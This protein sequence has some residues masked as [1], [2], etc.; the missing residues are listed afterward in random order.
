MPIHLKTLTGYSISV[1][2]PTTVTLGTLKAHI[3]NVYSIPENSQKLFHSAPLIDDYRTLEDYSIP[4]GATVYLAVALRGGAFTP[5]TVELAEKYKCDKQVCRKCY[6]RLPKNAT[7]C[8]KDK[9]GHSNDLR[10]KKKLTACPPK[11]A[12]K[13]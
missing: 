2:V 3:Q 6:A 9:C 7:N 12:Y 11:I 10:K 1:E 5:T 13:A 4:E 8:R